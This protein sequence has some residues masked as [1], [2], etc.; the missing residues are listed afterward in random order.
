MSSVHKSACV[1]VLAAGLVA[2]CAAEVPGYAKNRH[3]RASAKEMCI[4]VRSFV[5]ASLDDE[6]LR[7]AWFLPFGSYDDGSFDFYAPMASDP[8]DAASSAFYEKRVGQLTHYVDAPEFVEALATCL[9]V[10]EGFERT[11]W[12]RTE[13]VARAAFRDHKSG[14]IVAMRASDSTT[15]ILI[16]T[17]TWK[18]DIEASMAWPKSS[19]SGMPPNTS[20]ERT[21]ER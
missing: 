9:S 17:D 10:S 20:L 18:G 4:S 16:A 13:E 21:R 15:S 14:R 6:G 2:G 11:D 5:R 8:S 12:Q 1:L 7:R 19:S 3:G